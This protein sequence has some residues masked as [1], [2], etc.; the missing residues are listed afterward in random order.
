MAFAVQPSLAGSG[1]IQERCLGAQGLSS[2]EPSTRLPPQ[3]CSPVA[4]QSTRVGIR[5]TFKRGAD[6]PRLA[7]SADATPLSHTLSATPRRPCSIVAAAPG[8]ADE[9]D[10]GSGSGLDGVQVPS[11]TMMVP[12]MKKGFGAYGGGATL[13]KSKLDLSKPTTKTSPQVR[14]WVFRN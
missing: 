13:E 6:H 4:R 12:F 8:L 7:L 14:N 11:G 3:L 9:Q 1:L 10:Q 2:D 5:D